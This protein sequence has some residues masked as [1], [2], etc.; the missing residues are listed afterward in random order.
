MTGVT[1]EKGITVVT[2]QGVKA[3]FDCVCEKYT[4]NFSAYTSMKVSARMGEVYTFTKIASVSTICDDFENTDNICDLDYETEK[5]KHFLHGQ[6]YGISL[7][8][9]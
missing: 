8:W 7:M 2:E 4:D 9:K 6:V 5:E 1:G 3:E